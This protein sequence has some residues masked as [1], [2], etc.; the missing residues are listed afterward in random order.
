M[1]KL[2]LSRFVSEIYEDDFDAFGLKAPVRPDMQILCTLRTYL[3]RISLVHWGD[4]IQIQ[5][6]GDHIQIYFES[7]IFIRVISKNRFLKSTNLLLEKYKF[8][9]E[10]GTVL[11]CFER[12]EHT[13]IVFVRQRT[14]FLFYNYVHI[15]YLEKLPQI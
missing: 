3:H 12:M 15:H 7:K 4:H 9:L 11:K 2:T 1:I 8:I 14:L 6:T 10:T 5:Y 13:E